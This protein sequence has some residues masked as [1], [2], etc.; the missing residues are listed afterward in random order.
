MTKPMDNLFSDEQIFVDPNKDY[1]EELV[2]ENKKF[3]TPHDLAHAKAQSDAHITRLEREQQQLRE[4]LATRIKY[5]EFLDKLN[6]LPMQNQDAPQDHQGQTEDNT[7]MKLEDIERLLENKLNQKDSERTARQN[8]TTSVNKLQ[9]VYG[10]NYAQ[11]L[12][13]QAQELEVSEQFLQNM[14][15]TN[16]KALFRFLGID[17]RQDNN[18]SI[19]TSPPKSQLNGVSASSPSQTKGYSTYAELRK[20]KPQE[21]YSPRIQNEI[22]EKMKNMSEE[23]RER[24]LN[25]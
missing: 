12:K 24:F 9:E 6:S 8:L 10:P 21:Y 11:H 23:Q 19:F 15:Q 16:P 14:A 20:T 17:E 1:L 22:M 3:K 7:A 2:G 4:E 5:E 18:N 13:R 25:S